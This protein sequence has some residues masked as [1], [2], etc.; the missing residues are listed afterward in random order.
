MVAVSTASP[1][2]EMS[3]D[4]AD[5]HFLSWLCMKS[6]ELLTGVTFH[7][8]IYMGLNAQADFLILFDKNR[9]FWGIFSFI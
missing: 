3:W 8:T 2:V 5:F 9:R 1:S 7:N 6:L 4:A